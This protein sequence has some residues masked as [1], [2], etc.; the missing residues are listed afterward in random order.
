[1]TT[2][3][4]MQSFAQR[5]SEG[6]RAELAAIL[7]DEAVALWSL[8]HYELGDLGRLARALE[9]GDTW[10]GTTGTRQTTLSAKS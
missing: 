5:L 3:Q 10:Q 6:D 2:K 9:E 4:R 1:M 7:N 8:N